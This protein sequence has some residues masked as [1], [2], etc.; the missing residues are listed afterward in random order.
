MDGQTDVWAA[1]ATLFML[2][3]GRMVH[4]APTLQGAI[5]KA[6][7][8]PAPSLASVLAAVPGP[9]VHIV[10]RALA[11]EKGRRWPT[12]AAMRDALWEASVACFGRLPSLPPVGS[13]DAMAPTLPSVLQVAFSDGP[14]APRAALVTAPPP[15]LATVYVDA[16]SRPQTA[17][18]SRDRSRTLP[19][20][21]R[22]RRTM[23]AVVACAGSALMGVVLTAMIVT[24]S[25]QEAHVPPTAA[26]RAAVTATVG[27]ADTPT[28]ADPI[29]RPD[30]VPTAAC[31]PDCNPTFYLDPGGGKRFKPECFRTHGGGNP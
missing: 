4:E 9:L 8:Q 24:P 12:A 17:P 21:R 6:A 30:A 28:S 14:A 15:P 31:K 19:R 3:S 25:R 22:R 2:A 11:F 7:T 29:A 27:V 20:L 16:P 1:G 10:D 13:Q 5:L 23:V 26:S 18:V